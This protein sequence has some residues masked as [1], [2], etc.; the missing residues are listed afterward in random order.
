MQQVKRGNINKLNFTLP[1]EIYAIFSL[2]FTRPG[3]RMMNKIKEM[4]T[5]LM[6]HQSLSISAHTCRSEC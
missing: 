6:K 4:D 1:Q 5:A 2:Q 3:N